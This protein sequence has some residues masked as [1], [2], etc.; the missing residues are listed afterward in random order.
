MRGDMGAKAMEQSFMG[1]VLAVAGGNEGL[2]VGRLFCHGCPR[3]L[4]ALLL[5]GHVGV[6]DATS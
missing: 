3:G 6:S 2:S 1:S 4:P 5:A